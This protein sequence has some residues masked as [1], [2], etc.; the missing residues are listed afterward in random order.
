MKDK[1]TDDN[2]PRTKALVVHES[3]LTGLSFITLLLLI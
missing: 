3:M 2:L 1:F